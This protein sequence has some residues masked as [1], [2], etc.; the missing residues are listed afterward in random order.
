MFPFSLPEN[1]PDGK[2]L[3]ILA[4]FVQESTFFLVNRYPSLI[5]LVD[6]TTIL[7]RRLK[8]ISIFLLSTFFR[9]G[10]VFAKKVLPQNWLYKEKLILSSLKIWIFIDLGFLTMQIIFDRNCQYYDSSSHSDFKSLFKVTKGQFRMNLWSHPFYT[11]AH[12]W[13]PPSFLAINHH[14]NKN[15]VPSILTHNLWLS[16]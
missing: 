9:E 13:F 16:L 4:E 10:Y 7:N 6:N 1:L 8:L 2:T 14:N 12:L 3:L 5:N 11:H 15:W